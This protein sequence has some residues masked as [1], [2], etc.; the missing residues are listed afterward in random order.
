MAGFHYQFAVVLLASVRDWL[1]R[2]SYDRDDPGTFTEI[3]SDLVAPGA[4]DML[5]ITQIKRT[6]SSSAIGKA[7]D[8]L[9]SIALV[10]ATETPELSDRLRYR[11]VSARSQLQ[12]AQN[13]VAN[14]QPEGYAADNPAVVQFRARVAAELL[15]DPQRE[16]LTLLANEFRAS[17]PLGAVSGWLGRMLGAARRDDGFEA[18][19][20]EIW[21]D[22]QQLERST[23]RDRLPEG[24]YVWSA[25]DRAPA[26]VQCGQYLTG[27]RPTVRHL[28]EGF[29]APRERAYTELL[30]DAIAWVEG[31]PAMDG[32]E[33][34][35][36]MFWVAGRSG[37]GKSVALLHLLAGLQDEGYESILWLGNK[38]ELLPQ[39]LRWVRGGDAVGS[40]RVVIGVDDPYAPDKEEEA[41]SL[42]R[43]VLAE[44]EDVRQA[45]KTDALPVIFCCGPTE[46]AEQ[47]ASDFRG[48]VAVQVRELPAHTPEDREEL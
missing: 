2:T 12:D 11:I 10:A 17:S 7:L 22:L 47:F 37:C 14:W 25:A 26:I 41:S 30:E 39:A 1:S 42:W 3:L 20:E 9:L 5:V 34:V 28:R 35:L 4:G 40:G 6:Q 45:G 43:R 46:Q 21:N 16:L 31:E 27:E 18:V 48:E 32:V 29:F 23:E 24:I 19:A 13:S 15:P 8:E 36:P 38:V 44:L 33:V